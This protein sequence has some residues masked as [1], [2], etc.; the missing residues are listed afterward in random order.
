MQQ[1]AIGP[2]MSS[3]RPT[4]PTHSSLPRCARSGLPVKWGPRSSLPTARAR[5]G[6]LVADTRTRMSALAL[7]SWAELR[8]RT[9]AP[10]I[11]VHPEFWPCVSA[12]G[13]TS[14]AKFLCAM[15]PCLSSARAATKCDRNSCR[16]RYC[17]GLLAAKTE[18]KT[19]APLL[20][21]WNY[22]VVPWAKRRERLERAP[23]G[24]SGI[25][26]SSAGAYSLGTPRLM[27]NTF[28][29]VVGSNRCGG[30]TDCHRSISSPQIR[31]TSWSGWLRAKSLVS[32]LWSVS[33]ITP[34][35]IAS[36]GFCYSALGTENA[37]LRLWRRRPWWPALPCP[38]VDWGGTGAVGCLMDSSNYP[39]DTALVELKSRPFDFDPARVKHRHCFKIMTVRSESDSA[40]CVP[41]Q[42][43]KI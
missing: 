23:W 24:E 17:S 41:V 39:R 15:A 22:R 42:W 6:M 7:S 34:L 35:H 3:G 18:Y 37:V 12:G 14:L 5:A 32:N 21:P 38:T 11:P 16:L 10:S 29:E 26:I 2:H 8:G 28:V 36:I 4:S 9:V 43:A 40:G 33:P 20:A 30:G 31:T 19:L 25:A 13:T 1:P 27:S